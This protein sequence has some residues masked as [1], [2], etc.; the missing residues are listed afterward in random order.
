MVGRYPGQEEEEVA[1]T[2]VLAPVVEDVES[3]FEEDDGPRPCEACDKNIYPKKKTEE[4]V[5]VEHYIDTRKEYPCQGCKVVFSLHEVVDAYP[6]FLCLPCKAKETAA[7][8]VDDDDKIDY[9][10][11]DKDGLYPC[12]ECNFTY[13]LHELAHANPGFICFDCKGKK[14]AVECKGWNVGDKRTCEK[15]NKRL[16]TVSLMKKIPLC[17]ECN[18]KEKAVDDDD[19][20]I[21]E[22][23]PIPTCYV[24][25]KKCDPKTMVKDAHGWTTCAKCDRKQKKKEPVIGREE[26][27]CVACGEKSKDKT[28]MKRGREGRHFC[29]DCYKDQG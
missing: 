21:F 6:M 8:A 17:T 1:P 19:E 4:D 25:A 16:G 18:A 12:Q 14:K 27:E 15:C 10:T 28:L 24:C 22:S 5:K 29:L 23:S 13:A 20:D 7:A 3:E 2:Q 11:P 26:F 9:N